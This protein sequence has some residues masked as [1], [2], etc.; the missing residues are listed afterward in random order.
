MKG[1]AN[2]LAAGAAAVLGLALVPGCFNNFNYR[3]EFAQGFVRGQHRVSVLGVFKDGRMDF[4][5][6]DAVAPTMSTAF[7]GGKCPTGYRSDFVAEHGSLSS[8]IDDAARSDG[9]SDDLLTQLAPAAKGDLI[10]VFTLAGH[11]EKAKID[12]RE[13]AQPTGGMGPGGGG[14]GAAGIGSRMP[15]ARRG[16]QS[17]TSNVALSLSATMFSVASHTSV[18]V[19]EL[20][21]TGENASDAIAQFAA[22]VRDTIP[23]S[24]CDEWDWSVPIDEHRVRELVDR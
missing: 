5:A 18:G 22:K 17:A 6:W 19:I 3:S 14:G 23:G 11:V 12:I 13:P 2:S 16:P 15:L 9:L 21:Y 24:T 8:A 7:A 4:E 10:V 20:E 1:R